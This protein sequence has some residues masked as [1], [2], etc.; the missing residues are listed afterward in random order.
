MV[1][2]VV[3]DEDDV[4]REVASSNLFEKVK[5]RFCIEDLVTVVREGGGVQLNASEDL[6]TLALASYWDFRLAPFACPS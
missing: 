5:I 2:R 1:R 3:L 4:L 6:C